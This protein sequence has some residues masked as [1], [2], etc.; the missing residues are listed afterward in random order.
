MSPAKFS[1]LMGGEASAGKPRFAANWQLANW[2]LASNTSQLGCRSEFIPTS[3]HERSLRIVGLKPDLHSDLFLASCQWPVSQ[4][5]ER[6]E[7]VPRLIKFPPQFPNRF[8]RRRMHEI[9]RDV[10]EGFE[11][12]RA[13]Q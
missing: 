13:L 3:A 4:L 1:R 10:C 7:L 9:G 5:A 2:H 11:H 6:H 12:V 8:V